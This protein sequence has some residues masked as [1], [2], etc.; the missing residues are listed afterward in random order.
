MEIAGD[1]AMWTRP[2]TGDS[3]VSYL[4]P[5][6]SAVK[7]IF[8]SVLWGPAVEIVPI[9]AEICAPVQFHAYH[10][11]YGGPLRKSDN[12][13]DGNSYQLSATVLVNVCY[14]LY[15]EVVPYHRKD[16]LP[17]KALDWDAATTSPGHAYQEIFNRRLL[18]G[19]CYSVPSLGWHEFTP[20]YFGEFRKDTRVIED[21]PT[22][23]IPSMLRQVFSK[24]YNSE[25]AYLY[26]TDV[27]I[28]KGV[29]IYRKGEWPC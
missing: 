8:E 29:L 9:K 12:I 24:G 2:D 20:S 22:A 19:Q 21:L 7:A 1:T 13:K 3:P 14:R 11:N 26:D 16:R 25:V 4:A 17:Q 15:A 5:T 6:Y 23:M 10:T 28:V 27:E 18:R